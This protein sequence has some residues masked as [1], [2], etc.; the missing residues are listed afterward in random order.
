MASQDEISQRIGFV[1]ISYQI[2]EFPVGEF[3]FETSRQV[4]L[5]VKSLPIRICGLYI[6][7]SEEAWEPVVE[8]SCH[9][10]NTSLRVRSRTIVGSHDEC[11]L[12]LEAL[13][14]PRS[15]IPMMA[16]GT[17]NLQ[18][19]WSWIRDQWNKEGTG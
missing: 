16:D 8:L 1:S 13:G 6:C 11:I 7:Y 19:H 17:C 18:S 9:F 5:L 3:D 15:S 12:Q 10:M 4:A 2:G 14:I